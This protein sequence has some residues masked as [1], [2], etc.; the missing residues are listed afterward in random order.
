MYVYGSKDRLF[1]NTTLGCRSRCS[2]CYLPS[3][4]Y[5]VGASNLMI[6]DSDYVIEMVESRS[7]FI[8][9]KKGTIISLGCYSECWDEPVRESTLALITYFL[10][11]GNPVQFA[12]KRYVAC[13]DIEQVSKL[14]SW[15]GQLSIF[16]SSTTLTK[17]NSIERGTDSP[18]IRFRS[19]DL[20]KK[21]GVP[22]YLY[23]K[24]IIKS[25]TISDLNKYVDIVKNKD[26]SGVIIGSKF[27]MTNES[28][29][30][31]LAPIS[32]GKLKY[33][34]KSEEEEYMYMTLSQKVLTFTESVQAIDYWRNHA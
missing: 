29:N 22:V 7:D 27:I 5:E 13:K 1:I 25:V 17:W 33:S 26:V 16:I 2:Y 8:Q 20:T 3:L 34:K 24:P 23:I 30:N 15:R 31:K 6:K 14:I 11:K 19:F 12:T 28:N 21:T 9:G 18:D 4:D 32:N 10:R